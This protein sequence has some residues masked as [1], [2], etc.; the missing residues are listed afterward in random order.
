[1]ALILF[2]DTS[3]ETAY[4]GL[5]VDS[6]PVTVIQNNI[7]KQHA[8]FMHTALQQLM[9]EAGYTFMD[10]DAVA[11]TAG[12]GSYTGIR[13][14][15]SAAKGLCF[16]THKPLITLN[17]LEIL[18]VA[19]FRQFKEQVDDDT[20]CLPMIDA[21]RQEVFTAMFSQSLDVVSQPRALIINDDFFNEYPKDKKIILSGDGYFKILPI[22][23][24]FNMLT[25]PQA[26]GAEDI[27]LLAAKCFSL[28]KFEDVSSG[29]P[30]YI[31]SFYT[32]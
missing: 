13:V 12:P 10:V 24:S 21:R 20:L 11:V 1:M 2:I 29:K 31:K 26:Y 30:F 8:T 28:N 25:G 15:L 32:K 14:G 9:Q 18:A 6:Q 4:V 22:Q 7:Q 5:A 19:G 16:A 3:L 17:T 27:T 23:Q